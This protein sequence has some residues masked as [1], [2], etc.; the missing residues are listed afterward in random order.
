MLK[1]LTDPDGFFNSKSQETPSFKTPI[2]IMLALGLITGAIAFVS[3][4]ML[5]AG[6]PGELASMATI[7]AAAASFGGVIGI[8]IGWLIYAVIF[9][10]LSALFKG[11]GEFKRVMEFVAYGYIPAIAS[12]IISGICTLYVYS[13]LD[14]SNMIAAANSLLTDPVMR[15]ASV[16]GIVFTLWS[17]NIWIFALV[18]SRKLSVKHACIVVG[19]PV[20]LGIVSTI[21]NMFAASTI[22]DTFMT[23]ATAFTLPL[24]LFG[25]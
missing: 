11:Q 4:K 15:V 3:T 24:L 2:L 22:P 6:T 23:T 17:A 20:L 19:I 9:Y 1:V 21:Y 5:F 7:G 25:A 8:L 18:H 14:T 10:L 13:T 16:L 12:T